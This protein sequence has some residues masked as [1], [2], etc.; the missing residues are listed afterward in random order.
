MTPRIRVDFARTAGA[1]LSLDGA[2]TRADLAIH[3]IQ[4]REGMVLRVHEPDED[5]AGEPDDLVA[6]G[7]VH[8]DAAHGGWVLALEPGAVRRESAPSPQPPDAS[9]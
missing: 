6:E 4:L 1:G 7:V 2:D 8:F 3:A 5:E 9:S